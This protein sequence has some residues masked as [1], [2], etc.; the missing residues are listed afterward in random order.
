MKRF[1]SSGC[2]APDSAPASSAS[3]SSARYG[4]DRLR[5]VAREQ[6]EMMHFARRP[7]FDDEPGAGAQPLADEML[8][9]GRGGEQRGDRQQVG[10][11]LA[12]GHDQ[13]VV[14]EVDGVLRRRRERRERRFHAV[15]APRGRIA[16]VELEGLERAAGE[17]RGVTDLF[18]RAV[19][20]DRLL[21][22]EAH[23]QVRRVRGD[24]DGQQVRPRSDE[25]DE[26]HHE[27]FA[28]RIDRRIRHLREQ[29]LEIVVEDL[30]SPRQHRQRGVVA[31]RADRLLARARH[32]REDHLEILLR[33]AERL[34]AVEQRHLGGLRRRGLRQIVE[35]DPRAFDPLAVRLRRGERALQ[36][37]IVDDAALLGVDE[38]HLAR[39]QAP[40]RDDLALRNVEHAD[41]RGH[42]DVVVVGDD[43]ARRPQAVA[44]ERRADLPAVGERHRR[45]PVPRLHQRRVVFVEGAAVLVHQRIAGPGLGNHQHHR[46]RERVA[47][48]HEELERVV[49][50]RGIRLPVV[51][52]RPDL[53]EVL[54]QHRARDALLPRADPVDVAAQRVD[55]AVVADEPERVRE[56]PRRK[57]VGREALMHHRQRRHHGLVGEVREILADL[58]REQ[59]PLVDE[60]A[61]GHRRHVELLAVTK[62]QRLDRVARLLAD[63]VELALQRVLVHRGRSARDEDLA[64]DRLDVLRPLGKSAVVV[65]TS[66]QPRRIWP[67]LA[68]AR[69]ISCS[70]A[71]RDAGSFG[72]NTMPT[73][74]WP[75]AGSVRPCAPHA[76]RRN[77]SGS[78]IRM[79]A[80]SPCSG[81]A[82]V[83]PRCERL[84][85]IDNACVMMAWRF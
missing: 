12:V 3:V 27:L 58:V 10:R 29:L 41:L 11:H 45:G 55:L 77:R 59:H 13:D 32:R 52:Q 76:L 72:R 67:S 49:E 81:S 42:H 20:E 19:R 60:R 18:H 16:D 25:R 48:H 28:D 2:D 73:P 79:P 1:A 71:I 84:R 31:H 24:I 46:V 14:A 34:L 5:A 80:P 9:H 47:A 30:R 65:G 78:W 82:P 83:A 23:R 57:R 33:V 15:G 4:M 68:T 64:D 22:L 39:L 26:R 75:M 66:R 62:P 44:V 8:V 21:R 51:D 35:R 40:L 17:Q 74:Y 38:Q 53:V 54:A 50:R 56:I 70:H 36:F 37:G 43:E 85:R 69:S 6:R 7:R 63:D 61:R